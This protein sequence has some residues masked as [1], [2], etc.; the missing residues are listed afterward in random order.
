M[1]TQWAAFREEMTDI[2]SIVVP[3]RVIANDAIQI[4]LHVFSDA[5]ERAYGGCIYLRTVDT[6]DNV[7][8]RLLCSKSRVAPLRAV[9]LSCLELCGA[10]LAAQL[11]AKV[12]VAF[13]IQFSGECYWS[14]SMIVLVWLKGP[15]N[16]W[17]TFVANRVSQIQQIRNSGHWNH[18]LSPDNP[19]DIISRGASPSALTECRLWWFGPAW[20]AQGDNH[21]PSVVACPQEIPKARQAS[22]CLTVAHQGNPPSDL[23]SRY[24]SYSK[25][26]RITAYCLKFT[27]AV[28]NK[29][30]KPPSQPSNTQ[31]SPVSSQYLTTR[32]LHDAERVLIKFAQREQFGLEF[33]LLSA[34]KSLT[35][36]SP[37]LSLSP[38]LDENGLI[39]VDGRLK[40]APIPYDQRHS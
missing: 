20:L 28:A 24:S 15:S 18:V 13:R 23:F 39:R 19:T 4:E 10:L 21:W 11:T 6:A 22:T 35:P 34:Q 14:D 12:K 30:R 26:R 9:T 31:R 8:V 16:R 40:N 2:S 38:F 25:L 32:E 17:K 33:T 1:H 5:S 27:K 36:K 29:L 3:R 7:T 37:L